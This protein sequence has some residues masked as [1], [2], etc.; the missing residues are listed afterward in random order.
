M[1]LI[2]EHLYIKSLMLGPTT[3][4]TSANDIWDDADDARVD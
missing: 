1:Q 2:L 4:T 3:T